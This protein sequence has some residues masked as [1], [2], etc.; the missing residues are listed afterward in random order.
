[1]TFDEAVKFLEEVE[2]TN[3]NLYVI[4]GRC[5][6]KLQKTRLLVAVHVIKE[7]ATHDCVNDKRLIPVTPHH[8][9]M[10]FRSETTPYVITD[11]C[12]VCFYKNGLGLFD[13]M[14]SKK[15]NFCP[16]CGQAIDWSEYDEDG[17]MDWYAYMNRGV[18]HVE[19]I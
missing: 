4:T 1:M 3:L 17:K 14:L 12:P 13:S 6:G 19:R 2:E 7:C 9:K 5:S 18:E 10:E 15:T 16:R 11:N 8:T